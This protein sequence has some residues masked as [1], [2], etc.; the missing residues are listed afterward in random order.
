MYTKIAVFNYFHSSFSIKT[1]LNVSHQQGVPQLLLVFHY[2]DWTFSCH[3][4]FL[5]F[6]ILQFFFLKYFIKLPN[7][8]ISDEDILACFLIRC[9]N[10]LEKTKR[11]LDMYYSGR[12]IL[13]EIFTNRDPCDDALKRVFYSA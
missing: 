2:L 8:I 5:H 10:S 4:Y 6:R 13:P 7:L 11:K 9:K 12:A 1:N 3:K